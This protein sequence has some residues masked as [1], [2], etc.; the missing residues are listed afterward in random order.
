VSAPLLA[1]SG[2]TRS[3]G[4]IRALDG[5]GFIRARSGICG[6]IGPNGA[7]KTTLFGAISGRIAVDAGSIRFA[8]AELL[9][10]PAHR[11][12]ARGVV[13]TFQEC[14]VFADKT[15]LDNLLFSLQAKSLGGVVLR[16]FG[17]DMRRRR[18]ASEECR[19][20]LAVVG[21]ADYADRPAGLL[22]YGQRRLLE[23]AAALVAKPRLLLLDEPA[24]GVNPA[25]LERLS[26]F[27][28]A[29]RRR[30]DILLLIVEHNMEFIMALADEIVVMHQGAVLEQGSPAQIQASPRVIDAYLG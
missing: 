3:F 20:L 29:A 18:A 26:E 22:S 6:V 25:L 9:R 27:L 23:I 28:L 17:A 5:A 16:M 12:V 1:I 7:G 10:L 13:R 21:L 15:C 19:A 30:S 4:G 14:R 2:L 24:S 8:G 11:R